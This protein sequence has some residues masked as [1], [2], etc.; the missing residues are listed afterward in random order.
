MSW[1]PKTE[2]DNML[3]TMPEKKKP[4]RRSEVVIPIR[5]RITFDLRPDPALQA[6]VHA[7]EQRVGAVQNM[8]EVCRTAL[9][10]WLEKHGHLS[11]G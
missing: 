1:T 9:W 7:F 4:A 5:D 10:E 3:D 8:T 2:G 6:A 11:G